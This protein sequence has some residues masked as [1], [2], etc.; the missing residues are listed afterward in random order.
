MVVG[1]A[2]LVL[3]GAPNR[4]PTPATVAA[5]LGDAGFAV[6]G[7]DAA[8]GRRRPLTAVRRR[9]SSTA[10]AS[11]VK[12]YGRDSRD[13]DLLYRGYRTALLRGPS[14]DWPAASLEHDV[15]HEA[16]LCCSPLRAGVS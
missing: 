12:V 8:A 9:H 7:L 1:Q 3:V 15:E 11:F 14:D 16:L 5:G 10:D 13:A 2:I 6:D 4:R